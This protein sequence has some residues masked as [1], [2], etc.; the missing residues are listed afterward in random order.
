MT[1]TN[2][3]ERNT[4]LAIGHIQRQHI[5]RSFANRVG[6][7]GRRGIGT[8]DDSIKRPTS[9]ADVDDAWRARLAQQR[10]EE[11]GNDA[12]GEDIGVE[13]LSPDTSIVSW[14]VFRES[15]ASVVD[16]DYASR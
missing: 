10:H 3:I 4:F 9:R 2:G 16:E 1:R 8:R 12:D 11:L 14:T 7:I 5:Q 13:D 15:Y 6:T